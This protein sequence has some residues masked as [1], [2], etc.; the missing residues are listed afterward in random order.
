MGTLPGGSEDACLTETDL[1]P[2]YEKSQ[3]LDRFGLPQID[4]VDITRAPTSV[5]TMN[6]DKLYTLNIYEEKF[7]EDGSIRT[8]QNRCI[9]CYRHGKCRISM[10]YC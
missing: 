1:L 7:V 3:N 4:M 2:G 8:Y 9:V 6:N 10:F 5:S